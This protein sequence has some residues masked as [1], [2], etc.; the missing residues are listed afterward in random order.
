VNSPA[1]SR[2]NPPARARPDLHV[3]IVASE[4]APHAKT[5]GLGDMVAALAGSLAS[6]RVRATVLIPGYASLLAAHPFENAAD[7]GSPLGTPAR[8]LMARATGFD[9]AAIG[10][11]ELYGRSGIYLDQARRPWVDNCRR[12]GMLGRV[13]AMIASGETP[14]A[15]PDVVH[16]HDWHGGLYFGF[17]P[18]DVPTVLTVHNFAFQGRF[19]GA[20]VAAIAGQA[21]ETALNA[22]R[23]FGGI[24]FLRMACAGADVLTT[25]SEGYRREMQN[26]GRHNWWQLAAPHRERLIAIPNWLDRE[27]WDPARDPAITQIFDAGAIELR[28]INKRS[29]SERLQLDP[30]LPVAAVV[31]RV[32]A[33]KG[34]RWLCNQVERLLKLGVNLVVVGEGESRLLRR[35]EDLS[36]TS[37]CAG[38]LALCTPYTEGDA[39]RALAGAD[40]LIMPSLVE[41]HGLTQIQA[42]AYGCIPVVADVGGLAESIGPDAGFVFRASDRVSFFGALAQ[43]LDSLAN[44][45]RWSRLQK[46]AMLRHAE[47]KPAGRYAQQY[48]TLA[49]AGR[50]ASDQVA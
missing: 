21:H 36:R 3:L 28:S 24:S 29:L 14:L 37:R 9:I 15:R 45:A 32:T 11:D 6:F 44:P 7:L 8:L 17:R 34:F 35:L 38:R 18:P 4:L 1:T 31:S 33:A 43:A 49:R 5:G 2:A 39:R 22:A 46:A 26:S 25:V 12:F 10:C 41:P 19:P 13:A 16:I 48:A 20:D 30:K 27:R 47:N 50:L 23:L 40:L 42:Q